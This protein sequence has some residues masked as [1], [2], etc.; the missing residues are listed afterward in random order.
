MRANE[1]GEILLNIIFY[2][3][4]KERVGGKNRIE[5]YS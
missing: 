3:R 2:H 1:S 5:Q 4:R